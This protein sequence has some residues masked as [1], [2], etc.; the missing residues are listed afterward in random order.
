MIGFKEWALVCDALGRGEQSIILRKGG[1][2]EAGG[3]FRPE[4]DRFWLYPTHFHEQQQAGVKPAYHT[5]LSDAEA[6]RPPAGAV[7]FSHYV[8]VTA[9]YHL[10]DLD[11]A[12]AL[13]A[14]HVWTA[15]TVA[16][17][18]HYRRPGLYLLV[19]R[20]FATP[21][22]VAVPEH[23]EYA[24]C[25]TWV[26]LLTA[27]PAGADAGAVPVIGDEEWGEVMARIEAVAGRAG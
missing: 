20:A 24:G 11:T 16:Q 3:A 17:R 7:R 6:D 10:T 2:A 18:F 13:D 5:L 1:I 26:E 8:H 12:L 25:K 19:V 9:V 15:E 23:P 21:E 22:P 14:L 27:P 4:H